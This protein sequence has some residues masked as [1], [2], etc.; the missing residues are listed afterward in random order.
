MG[1]FWEEG[2]LLLCSSHWSELG[3]EYLGCRRG[4]SHLVLSSETQLS[5]TR[6]R[7]VPLQSILGTGGL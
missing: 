2:I 4:A 3:R 1:V 5:A 6:P 7:L